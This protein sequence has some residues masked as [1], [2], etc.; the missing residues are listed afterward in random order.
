MSL[1]YKYSDSYPVVNGQDICKFST[2]QNIVK[3]MILLG[4]M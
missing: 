3:D 4:T 1:Y 2:K